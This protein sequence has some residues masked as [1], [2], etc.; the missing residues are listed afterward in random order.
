MEVAVFGC[1]VEPE[2]FSDG[3]ADVEGDVKCRRFV[4]VGRRALVVVY[5]VVVDDLGGVHVGPVP[6]GGEVV[7]HDGGE[8]G[9]GGPEAAVGDGVAAGAPRV[10]VVAVFEEVAVEHGGEVVDVYAA[11]FAGF[12]AEGGCGGG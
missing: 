9:G 8:A 1:E 6:G 11:V 2:V 4:G 12:I 3:E 5:P 7:R 10:E